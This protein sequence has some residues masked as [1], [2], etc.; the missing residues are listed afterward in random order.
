[1]DTCSIDIAMCSVIIVKSV[2]RYKPRCGAKGATKEKKGKDK[3]VTQ[4]VV[5]ARR[6]AF[7]L[8]CLQEA[9]EPCSAFVLPSV[10]GFFIFCFFV[11]ECSLMMYS[12]IFTTFRKEEWFHLVSKI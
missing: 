7:G 9:A 11:G 6:R 3:K 5:C 12:V 2:I 1:M 4:L 8:V 10:R